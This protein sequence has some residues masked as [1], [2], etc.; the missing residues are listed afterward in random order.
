MPRVDTAAQWTVR[1]RRKG[2]RCAARSRASARN[3][4]PTLGALVA[5]M[6]LNS[7]AR[8][9]LPFPFGSSVTHRVHTSPDQNSRFPTI[10]SALLP[11]LRR[12]ERAQLPVP[13]SRTPR[14]R[15]GTLHLWYESNTA[16]LSSPLAGAWRTLSHWLP[17]RFGDGP[18][19][20]SFAGP[21]TTFVKSDDPHHL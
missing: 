19:L 8:I 7:R 4:Q 15:A 17:R 21:A 12:P 13:R 2:R 11:R 5:G 14:R 3:F 10:P 16:F 20:T 18:H 1:E 9:V 6:D